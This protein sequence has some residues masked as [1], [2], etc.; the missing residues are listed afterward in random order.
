MVLLQGFVS[1]SIGVLDILDDQSGVA[2]EENV[3]EI[4]W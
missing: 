3:K 1:H 4:A 2:D